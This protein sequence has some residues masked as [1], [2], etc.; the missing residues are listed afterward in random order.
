MKQFDY[1]AAHEA[2]AAPIARKLPEAALKIYRELRDALDLADLRQ[3]PTLDCPMPKRIRHMFDALDNDALALA[4]RALYSFGHWASGKAGELD[5]GKP[6]TRGAY[7]KFSDLA[8]QVLRVRL[9]L[10][11]RYA[12]ERHGF[13]VILHEGALRVYAASNDLWSWVEVGPANDE[14]L[15]AAREWC[16]TLPPCPPQRRSL[17][18]EDAAFDAMSKRPEWAEE[19]L[20]DDWRALLDAG[21]NFMREE[22]L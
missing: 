9:G 8:D 6:D 4:S 15:N 5:E 1:K 20:S 13:G 22:A 18:W 17:K 16:R 14:T 21:K 7:W 10:A 11:P 3:G 12:R 19:R 2:V